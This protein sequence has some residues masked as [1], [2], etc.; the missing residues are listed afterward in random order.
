MEVTVILYLENVF[1][2]QAGTGNYVQKVSGYF[3]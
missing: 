1:V 2:S 3:Q